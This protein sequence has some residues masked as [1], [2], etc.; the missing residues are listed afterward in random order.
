MKTFTDYTVYI[1]VGLE[2]CRK[3]TVVPIEDG[4]NEIEMTEILRDYMFDMIDWGYYK[5]KDK[6]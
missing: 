1:D 6:K 4:T 5:T 2:G 3:E